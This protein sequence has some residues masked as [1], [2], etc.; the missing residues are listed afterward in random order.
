MSY[1][2]KG[3]N[4]GYAHA[5]LKKITKMWKASGKTDVL[6][7]LQDVWQVMHVSL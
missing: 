2:A 7:S 1:K 3:R 5:K 4:K 6:Q